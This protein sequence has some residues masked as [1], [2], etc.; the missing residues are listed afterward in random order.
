[1]FL[2]FQ[3]RDVLVSATEDSTSEIDNLVQNLVDGIEDHCR[4]E[5]RQIIRSRLQKFV[6]KSLS[7]KDFRILQ[8][9]MSKDFKS[10][11]KVQDDELQSVCENG[12]LRTMV[13]NSG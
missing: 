3:R 10:S 1:L 7:H 13:F 8:G 5:S 4:D 11:E 2:R 6:G 9:V 12:K